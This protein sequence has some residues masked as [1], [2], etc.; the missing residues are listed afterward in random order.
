MLVQRDLAEAVI[1]AF[2]PPIVDLEIPVIAIGWRHL[3]DPG[4][5]R[6]NRPIT[7]GVIDVGAAAALLK[8]RLVDGRKLVG[9]GAKHPRP[10][11]KGGRDAADELPRRRQPGVKFR[12]VE[13]CRHGRATDA[14]DAETSGLLS[15]PVERALP[16]DDN[17][18]IGLEPQPVAG[19][20]RHA[21][22]DLDFA[23]R[24]PFDLVAH[25]RPRRR[26]TAI[27]MVAHG[28]G[29]DGEIEHRAAR[30]GDAVIARPANR[31]VEIF[32]VG[33]VGADFRRLV[34]QH[35]EEG[36]IRVRRLDILFEPEP[37]QAREVAKAFG[38][39]QRIGGHIGGEDD[40]AR[41]G[42]L[43]AEIGPGGS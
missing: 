35:I 32:V 8:Q 23:V 28:I 13:R 41:L 36:K 21:G 25:Q 18:G 9:V 39:H 16:D 17:A 43:G 14:F 15:R 34:A 1:E 22:D 10:I 26:A 31:G 24:P 3:D 40:V 30:A 7:M 27:D 19:L 38:L 11:G 20:R 4:L 5:V 6:C 42:Q 12:R 33:V 37:R 29:D 2:H